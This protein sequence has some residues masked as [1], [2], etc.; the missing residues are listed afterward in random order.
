MA[1]KDFIEWVERQGRNLR[2]K[3]VDSPTA[4]LDPYELAHSLGVTVITPND[5]LG[6]SDHVIYQLLVKDQDSW[7]AGALWAP[8]SRPFIIMNPT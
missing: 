8:N 4:V 1:K 3:Q 2:G 6:L 7:S 5:I